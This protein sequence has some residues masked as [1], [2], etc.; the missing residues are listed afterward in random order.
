[1]AT[2][3]AASA[4]PG[5]AAAPAAVKEPRS[6]AARVSSNP[7]QAGTAEAGPVS[8]DAAHGNE[9]AAL[10]QQ[11]AAV[12]APSIACTA[13]MQQKNAAGTG[14]CAVACAAC[15]PGVGASQPGNAGGSCVLRSEAACMAGASCSGEGDAGV[16]GLGPACSAADAVLLVPG[17]GNAP[18]TDTVPAEHSKAAVDM[19][20]AAA[21]GS[22]AASV[23]DGAQTKVPGI[24]QVGRPAEAAPAAACSQAPPG[25][26]GAVPVGRTGELLPV[27]ITTYTEVVTRG[28]GARLLFMRVAVSCSLQFH[29]HYNLVRHAVLQVNMTRDTVWS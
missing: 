22:A 7:Y 27:G 1:M 16:V 19:A 6:N 14:S 11:G 25:A 13:G 5:P 12:A 4:A 20:R 15:T 23:Y 8:V 28:H 10:C 17:S 24:T 2:L 21:V 18:H 9:G 29:A 3:A 26:P